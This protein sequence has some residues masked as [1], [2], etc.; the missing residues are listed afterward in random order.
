MQQPSLII[1]S[2]ITPEQSFAVKLFYQ[3][4][5]SL[6]VKIVR[7]PKNPKWCQMFDEY[8]FLMLKRSEDETSLNTDSDYVYSDN[9]LRYK[10]N[11]L[12]IIEKT[13]KELERK[14]FKGK[15]VEKKQIQLTRYEDLQSSE[16]IFDGLPIGEYAILV[17]TD[18][19]FSKPFYDFITVTNLNWIV[20]KNMD[21][22]YDIHV[23]N[24]KTGKPIPGIK[25]NTYIFNCPQL[26]DFNYALR[27]NLKTYYTDNDGFVQIMPEDN[28]RR[29]V[30]LEFSLDD[31]KLKPNKYLPLS[32]VEYIP[33]PKYKTISDPLYR[34]WRCLIGYNE[35]DEL[36]IPEID[37]WDNEE[38]QSNDE[39]T[40]NFPG[41]YTFLF[42]DRL[43]YR[44]EQI[45]YFKGISC[46][47]DGYQCKAEENKEIKTKL[48]SPKNEIIAEQ[49]STTNEFGSYSGEF[50]TEALFQTGKYK[51]QTGNSIK[52]IHLEEYKQ[53]T[54]KVVVNIPEQEY[55]LD[56]EL[57]IDGYARSLTDI[58]IADAMVTIKVIRIPKQQLFYWQ[59]KAQ[60]NQIVSPNVITG[61]DGTFNF[62]LKLSKPKEEI[63]KLLGFD[64]QIL[65]SVTDINGETQGSKKNIF[66]NYLSK[67]VSAPKS[68]I[69]IKNISIR[70]SEFPILI[71]PQIIETN[72]LSSG[73]I[74]LYQL[75]EADSKIRKSRLWSPPTKQLYTKSEWYTEYPGN[76]Y[77]TET[78]IQSLQKEDIIDQLSFD[79][80]QAEVYKFPI[81]NCKP[82]RYVAEI[83]DNKNKI[84][85]Q[86][87][88]V[89]YDPDSDKIPF[90]TIGW[91]AVVKKPSVESSGK[92]LIGSSA[93]SQIIF[94]VLVNNQSVKKEYFQLQNEQLILEVELPA[95]CAKL[96]V[97]VSF[98]SENRTYIQTDEIV[99]EEENKL[100]LDFLSFRKNLNPGEPEQW[101]L[102]ILNQ[103][104][105]IPEAELLATLYDAS[106]DLLVKNDWKINLPKREE[107]QLNWFSEYYKWTDFNLTQ[108]G[109]DEFA[110]LDSFTEFYRRLSKQFIGRDFAVRYAFF[111]LLHKWKVIGEEIDWTLI[112]PNL[113]IDNKN[114]KFD[115]ENF[116]TLLDYKWNG[117]YFRWY[118]FNSIFRWFLGHNRYGIFD[119]TMVYPN[120]AGLDD[121][122]E[123]EL[124]NFETTKLPDNEEPDLL[125]DIEVRTFFTDTVFFHPHIK[126]DKNGDV[127]LQFTIPEQL[128][129]WQMRG[130]VHT[131]QMQYA[132][133]ENT[134]ITS[135][136]LMLTVNAPRFFREGD[137][138]EFPVK[139]SNTLTKSLHGKIDLQFFDAFTEELVN[140]IDGKAEHIVDIPANSNTTQS[141]LVKT[142]GKQHALKY[143]VVI[144]AE[145]Y[146][147]GE[148][149]IIPVL[150]N[151]YLNMNESYSLQIPLDETIEVE[152]PGLLR[153][154]D[155][156]T[157]VHEN[158]S[159][160]LSSNTS[161]ELVDAL[162]ALLSYPYGCVEQKFSKYYSSKL[163]I[164]IYNNDEQVRNYIGLIDNFQK[165]N[166]PLQ[167]E[168][169]PFLNTNKQYL[170]KNFKEIDKIKKSLNEFENFLLDVQN[171][172]GGIPWFVGHNEDLFITQ[173]IVASFGQM[174]QTGLLVAD[175]I[176]KINKVL[177]RAIDWLDKQPRLTSENKISFYDVH[178]L[179]ARSFF[180]Q[181]EVYKE[182]QVTFIKLVEFVK[183]NWQNFDI[184]CLAMTGVALGRFKE[185]Q[186]S[187][188]II[189]FLI[190]QK[191]ES[192]KGICWLN[193]D[194]HVVSYISQSYI[195]TQV[196]LIALFEETGQEANLINKMKQ[197]LFNQKKNYSWGTTKSTVSA[198]NAVF[199]GNTSNSKLIGGIVKL[200][201]GDK[202]F[203]LE[204]KDIKS[205]WQHKYNKEEINSNLGKISI[206]QTVSQTLFLKVNWNYFE[207]ENKITFH[208]IGDVIIQK[209][210]IDQSNDGI[211]IKRKF[212]L[213]EE[214]RVKLIIQTLQP[215]Q[216][217]HIKD[218]RPA[219]SEP[220]EV[221]SGNKDINH[222]NYYTEIRDSS[223]NFFIND[224]WKGDYVIEYTIRLSH[225]GLFS[226]GIAQLQCMYAPELTFYSNNF[227]IEVV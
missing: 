102:K 191:I 16:F 194:R 126:P 186:V 13:Q 95:N 88:F 141:W 21:N 200:Q 30:F 19:N 182:N 118:R 74:C 104:G 17:D 198:L 43:I 93:V 106:L 76:E 150:K 192:P 175:E 14:L 127:V 165:V 120:L 20:R 152:I 147:D 83:L 156:E 79:V 221:F 177:K 44:P 164:H 206:H 109:F 46:I 214:I 73:K 51:I 188:E 125:S 184:H 122:D 110:P 63:P 217:I 117:V 5:T 162:A 39:N 36:K 6:W 3:D 1:E 131:K 80:K 179:Y 130:L 132:L 27:E 40:N 190:E 69:E 71:N 98:F 105:N 47:F 119:W 37:Y 58:P 53:P 121:G 111:K 210:L 48:L 129:K 203:E 9:P 96:L 86:Q 70:E 26:F 38:H 23:I 60:K 181:H 220:G 157:I 227:Q 15:A 205:P 18:K 189:Q 49:V 55:K 204:T 167:A 24:R 113:I 219:G 62:S 153:A 4:T 183:E 33:D 28:F 196:I 107:F 199:K 123:L 211:G 67:E 84:V 90:H 137:D 163:A 154:K 226:V 223:T 32:K 97:C 142:T 193:R 65:V 178:Y 215:L 77:E 25:I 135:K 176:E 68:R 64:F 187:I 124:S 201:S 139:I 57:I 112:Y 158:F 75:A 100:N 82:G 172:S 140:C 12:Q 103:N 8:R 216:Y 56:E 34:N 108:I 218:N 10:P 161:W 134:I 208:Q 180:V 35:D 212:K 81:I 151:N 160:E 225:K 136:P 29:K 54:F 169:F 66:V 52:T 50:K 209:Q 170:Y 91:M 168:D 195:E 202:K 145:G 138:L 207:Y 101:K 128:T 171:K 155:S 115:G 22:G 99:L 7:L 72:G 85:E 59:N 94:E 41:D 148:E 133:V 173:H 144:S 87:Y 114:N 89:F 116:F 45:V 42:T 197:W 143:R 222:F 2:A 78:Q 224:L 11:G 166:V 174:F 61:R 146:T 159:I 149:K 185:L 31:D 92:Y 213:G